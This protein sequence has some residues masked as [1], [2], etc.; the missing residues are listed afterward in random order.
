[1]KNENLQKAVFDKIKNTILTSALEI[2]KPIYQNFSQSLSRNII[3]NNLI[4][5]ED[6][7]D[8]EMG[9]G[10]KAMEKIQ[11]SQEIMT[12]PIVC[13]LNGLEMIDVKN[14]QNFQ[15]LKK[16]MNKISSTYSQ[17][18]TH[19]SSSYPNN[20]IK[21]NEKNNKV[22]INDFKYEKML[23]TQ[24][25][26][27]QIIVNSINK[28][29]YNFELVNSFPREELTQLAYYDRKLI[30]NMS[31]MSLKLFFSETIGAYK[32]IYDLISQEGIFEIS[33]EMFLWA[34]SNT[35]S[36]KIS[37]IDSFSGDDPQ[38]GKPIELIAPILEYINH[39]SSKENVIVE[40]D[41]DYETKTSVI[42]VYSSQ[43][44]QAGDQL[45]M[46]YGK[47]E[48]YNNRQFINR[49]GFFDNENPKKFIELPFL[50]D[51]I[52]EIFEYSKEE[53]LQKFL[54]I[55]KNENLKAFKT[56]LLKKANL[57]NYETKFF[58]VN[59]YENK[60]DL[61]LIKFLRIAFL[62]EEDI[63]DSNSKQKALSHNFSNKF[64]DKNEKNVFAF[65]I[66]ILEKYFASI[67]DNN[68]EGLI[69][70]LGIIDNREKFMLKNMYK[71]E[72]EEKYLLDKNLKYLKKKL[73]SLI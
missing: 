48:N 50:L 53:I 8:L 37:V 60:F 9:L 23:Q 5:L 65:C 41:Y 31:S 6:Y 10:L 56:E 43:E 33:Q 20:Q 72:N 28:N 35:L 40:P 73:N 34:Y 62:E 7:N 71:L 51:E 70:T 63:S 1:M 36:R 22:K 46:D 24:S 45:L 47:Y 17:I 52:F 12:I 13:G 14:D 2:S 27:W 32:Y 61:E 25:L 21:F 39:S 26:L 15:I 58:K 42:R 69:E 19:D 66:K 18:E 68:Y 67:K 49:Y 55:Q 3:I 59:I 38:N 16:L 64:F 54:H 30:E 4:Q 44:I 57:L 29:S 11:K